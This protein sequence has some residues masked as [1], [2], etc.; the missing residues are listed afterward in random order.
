MLL[1]Y[2]VFRKGITYVNWI[3]ILMIISGVTLITLK[4][5]TE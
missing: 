3:G 4:G 5:V 1:S 2:Y